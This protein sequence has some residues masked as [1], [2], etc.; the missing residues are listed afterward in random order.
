M[1]RAHQD[2]LDARHGDCRRLSFSRTGEAAVLQHQLSQARRDREEL[3][4]AFALRLRPPWRRNVDVRRR[5]PGPP[6]PAPFAALSGR[7]APSYVL[8]LA[9]HGA[10]VFAPTPSLLL[11][12]RPLPWMPWTSPARCRCRRGEDGLGPRGGQGREGDALRHSGDLSGSAVTGST[13]LP[14]FR[15]VVLS[16]CTDTAADGFDDVVKVF[17]A[18]KERQ[19][20]Q[21]M[22]HAIN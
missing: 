11:P 17:I 12:R 4:R 3:A 18:T 19:M 7:A 5:P 14:C 8:F 10:T 20:N 16:L 22:H 2:A 21:N 13:F 1:R 15:W 9:C 6:S